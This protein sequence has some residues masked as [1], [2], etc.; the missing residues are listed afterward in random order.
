M[1]FQ[2]NIAIIILAA[3]A[4]SRMGQT[5]QLLPWKDTTLLGNAIRTAKAS[6]ASSVVV[7]LG[8]NAESIRK[9]ISDNQIAIVENLVWDLGLGS[10]IACGT[11]FLIKKKNKPNGIFI[12]LADQPLIDT[13]YLNAMMVAFN[14]EQDVI[15]A[16]AYENGAG[17]P[18]LFSENYYR[19]LTKLDD[20]S[21]AK[22]LIQSQKEN[23]VV[24]DLEQK[25]VDIDTKTDYDNLTRKLK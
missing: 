11:D 21:G 20:D 18:A 12:M 16:T 23:V 8:A 14:P 7:V 9:E 17:V 6:D 2:K 5:K 24:L 19:K 13:A 3:G 15:I 10:S 1:A 22:D 25:T 4:S